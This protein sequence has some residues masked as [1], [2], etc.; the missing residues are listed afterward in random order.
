M[1]QIV[2]SWNGICG[3]KYHCTVTLL[4]C[5]SI[6]FLFP[7]DTGCNL[8]LCSVLV[9]QLLYCFVKF[10]W[11]LPETSHRNK[12]VVWV[13][14]RYLCLQGLNMSLKWHLF[15]SFSVSPVFLINKDDFW[16]VAYQWCCKSSFVYSYTLM[17]Y[18]IVMVLKRQIK[19][20]TWSTGDLLNY[21]L[22]FNAP[23]EYMEGSCFQTFLFPYII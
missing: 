20:Y 12:N 2:Q 17:N 5:L 16:H 23:I 10:L 11:E 7:W 18:I 3:G 6:H 8:C 4:L 15:L 19:N 9:H 13:S 22:S 1:L 21:F 14:D